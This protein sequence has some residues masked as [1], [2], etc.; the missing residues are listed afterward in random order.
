MEQREER[1][2]GW[3]E[4]EEQVKSLFS[5]IPQKT[6]GE[7][8]VLTCVYMHRTDDWRH[9]VILTGWHIRLFQLQTGNQ[10]VWWVPFPF[11]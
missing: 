9:M 6:P 4:L 10:M 3:E 2:S 1:C 7:P 8:C 11:Q 5:V